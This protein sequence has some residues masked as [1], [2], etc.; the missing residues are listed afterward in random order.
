MRLSRLIPI[1]IALFAAAD[2]GA[3]FVPIDFVAFRAWETM[4]LN[5]APT[6]PF[7]ASMKYQNLIA[8]GD[9]SSLGNWPEYHQY[10]LETVST[11][12]YGWRNPAELAE[13]PE[14]LGGFV[15]GD[16]FAAGGGLSDQHTLA[17]RL[18]ELLGRPLYNLGGGLPGRVQTIRD[19]ATRLHVTG[20]VVIYEIMERLDPPYIAGADQP[21]YKAE[22]PPAGEPPSLRERLS[23]FW[24]EHKV[25][26]LKIVL[27]RREQDL[28]LKL[29]GQQEELARN[30]QVL[31]RKMTNGD[32]MLFMSW[33]AVRGDRLMSP[34][35]FVWLQPWLRER[36]LTLIVMLVPSK[37]HVYEKYLAPHSEP[38]P[39]PATLDRLEASLRQAG[40]PV[41][42]VTSAL[43]ARAAEL[44]PG[45]EY[46]YWIDDTHWSPEGVRVAAGAVA[47]VVKQVCGPAWC[48]AS[49]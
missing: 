13:H 15:I 16:S 31:M 44:Y 20:G 40:V 32:P 37:Y 29:S 42:N 24:E 46:V 38:V 1:V 14:Q 34:D 11:D 25:S 33:D 35:Y 9:L 41:V 5:P 28:K 49:R 7:R 26:V 30:R 27:R 6:G 23:T 21:Y 39:S 8:H 22:L 3:R 47:E 36:G 45:R 10:R 18:G 43:T 12:K 17:A 48:G 19:A 4:V 2:V